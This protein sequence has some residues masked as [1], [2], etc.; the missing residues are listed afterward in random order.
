[1]FCIIFLN[2][3]CSKYNEAL[4]DGKPPHLVFDT[5][6]TGLSSETVKSITSVLGIPTVSTS[7][8]QEGD[9]R[10]WRGLKEAKTDNFLLQARFH[11]ALVSSSQTILKGLY[12][13]RRTDY[14]TC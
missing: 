4:K 11:I 9:L 7:F 12:M 14:A 13:S 8:G 5:T 10:Q 6:I 2:P 3:V 1:M